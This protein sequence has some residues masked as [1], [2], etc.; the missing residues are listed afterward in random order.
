[1]HDDQVDRARGGALDSARQA[2]SLLTTGPHP[3]AVDGRDISGLPA[4]CVR[5]DEVR[6]VVLH[7]RC[8]QALRDRVWVVLVTRSRAEGGAWTVGCAGV[9]LPALTAIAAR[10][11]ARF[12]AD[13]AD[14][15]SAVLA[16]FLGEL[17]EVDL[18]RPRIMNRLRWAAFR[19]GYAALREA[20][21]APVPICD[22]SARTRRDPVTRRVAGHPDVVL[23]RAIAEGVVT[24]D[25]AELIG[26]TRLDR[27]PLTRLAAER[28]SSYPALK[29]QRRR[30]EHRLLAHLADSDE[31]PPHTIS[32][33]PERSPTVTD[34]GNAATASPRGQRPD[35][36]GAR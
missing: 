33:H 2:F 23:I 19:A 35:S 3:L 26:Q 7:R 21:D 27:R 36:G 34:L 13:P 8:P 14:L 4:R 32:P 30:A 1:M 18:D 22:R 29:Q 6:E 5:L 10:L 20:L 31:A 24:E 16:G 25:D 15:H 9:A 28:G 17:A 12:A 11:S